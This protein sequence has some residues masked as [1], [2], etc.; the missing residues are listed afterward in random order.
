MKQHNYFQHFDSL[1]MRVFVAD[2][3]EAYNFAAFIAKR[4]TRSVFRTF[5]TLSAAQRFALAL[6]VVRIAYEF[7]DEDVDSLPIAFSI[8]ERSLIASRMTLDELT[9]AKLEQYDVRSFAAAASEFASDVSL[10]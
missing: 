8:I 2:V 3:F 7:N 5:K 10:N 6:E 9:T 4:S 1:V